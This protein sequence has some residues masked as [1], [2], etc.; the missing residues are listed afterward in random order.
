MKEQYRHHG[1]APLKE[2]TKHQT[3]IAEF[4]RARAMFIKP[5]LATTPQM[6]FSSFLSFI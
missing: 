5:R 6:A 3:M 4:S 1:V 2:G